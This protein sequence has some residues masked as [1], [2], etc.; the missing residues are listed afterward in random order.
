MQLSTWWMTC[1]HGMTCAVM[2]PCGRSPV[3]PASPRSCFATTMP[4]WRRLPSQTLL[5]STSTWTWW[6][7]ATFGASV[8]LGALGISLILT[9]HLPSPDDSLPSTGKRTCGALPLVAQGLPVGPSPLPGLNTADYVFI[10]DDTV[11]GLLKPPY[12]GPFHVLSCDKKYFIVD[13]H[14]LLDSVSV[15]RLKAAFMT[16]D[17]DMILMIICHPHWPHVP[18]A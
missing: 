14:G 17:S 15:D 11:W 1:F 9:R 10:C 5:S 2:S 7:P 12:H 4:P 3:L 18:P 8:H 13:L 16:Y 6:A